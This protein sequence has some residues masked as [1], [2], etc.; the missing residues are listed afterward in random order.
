MCVRERRGGGERDRVTESDI[1]KGRS[2]E[3]RRD[4]GSQSE[5][6]GETVRKRYKQERWGGR[7]KDIHSHFASRA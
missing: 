7:E 6:E 2:R 3:G 1:D 5:R 4:T